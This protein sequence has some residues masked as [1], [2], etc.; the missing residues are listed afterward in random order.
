MKQQY[1]VICT[2]NPRFYPKKTFIDIYPAD[3]SRPENCITH[4]VLLQMRR[5]ANPEVDHII[6]G[7]ILTDCGAGNIHLQYETVTNRRL[8]QYQENIRQRLDPAIIKTF[9]EMRHAGKDR[10]LEVSFGNMAVLFDLHAPSLDAPVSARQNAL[11]EE[12]KRI[13][14]IAAKRQ[15]LIA[16][17]SKE[18]YANKPHL[19]LA[20]KQAQYRGD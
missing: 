7:I 8:R 20:W 15:E 12:N 4:D 6:N 1:R 16:R 17:R 9:H 18:P 10:T 3:I 5:L 11:I 13:R 14:Y 2:E 19:L